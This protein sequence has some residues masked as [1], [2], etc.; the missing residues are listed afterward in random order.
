M[1]RRPIGLLLVAVALLTVAIVPAIGGRVTPGRA[2][3]GPIPGPPAVGDCVGSLPVSEATVDATGAS[4]YQSISAVSCRAAHEGEVVAVLARG[5]AVAPVEVADDD[6]V[7]SFDDPNRHDCRVGLAAALIGGGSSRPFAPAIVFGSVVTGPTALQIRMGQTWVACVGFAQAPSG[8]AVRYSGSLR[9]GDS[10]LVLQSDRAATVCLSSRNF[11]TEHAVLCS[12]P[13]PVETFAMML[14]NEPTLTQDALD[15]RCAA[16]VR[17][18]TLMPDPTAGQRL[19][20][21]AIAAHQASDGTQA[22]GLVTSDLTGY[23]RCAV[24][25]PTGSELGA[26]L[27]GLGDRP[28]PWSS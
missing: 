1:E 28:V 22:P 7:V 16:V 14:T 9:R 6:G 8:G 10:S 15:Q 2:V 26:S 3:I 11:F 21:T 17:R 12:E 20:V 4:R 23:A 24:V 27:A 25:A 19:S 5:L 18:A 13:H